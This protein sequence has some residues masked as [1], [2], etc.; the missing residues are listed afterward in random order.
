MSGKT[1]E[2][3]IHEIETHIA[4]I[5]GNFQEWF[6]SVSD[7]P[8]NA[9]FNVHGLRSSGDAWIA[10]KAKD[11]LQ[12]WDVEEYFRT[13]RKTRGARGETSLDHI[14]VYAYRMK[15]HTKP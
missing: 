13:V 14:Y 12:A 7:K 1:R 5:G 4:N 3:I 15:P 2:Q 11:D 10:R 8:K 6:L 9:L